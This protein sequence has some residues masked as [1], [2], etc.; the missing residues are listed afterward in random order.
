MSDNAMSDALDCGADLLF[1][2]HPSSEL[3]G[4]V[5]QCVPHRQLW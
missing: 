1:S 3:Y 4:G 5:G 2:G